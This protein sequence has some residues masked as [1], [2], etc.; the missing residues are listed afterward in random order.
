M[1]QT[2]NRFSY[3]LLRQDISAEKFT[4]ILKRYGVEVTGAIVREWKVTQ[5]PKE[6]SSTVAIALN[7]SEA[8][9]LS[10]FNITPIK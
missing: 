7:I 1:I 5:V 6:Y 8:A 9:L 3:E 10:D 4:R 2:V